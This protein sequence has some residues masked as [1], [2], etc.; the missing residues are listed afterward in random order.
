MFDAKSLLNSILGGAQQA[1]QAGGLSDIINQVQQGG[2]GNMIGSVLSQATQGVRDA[3]S[4]A[5]AASG[6]LGDRAN[7]ML[8][9][10]TG[11]QGVGDLVNKA[12]TMLGE[13]P[14]VA[15]AV[16]GGLGALVLGT[17]GGR[18]MAMSAAKLGGLALIGGLAYKA[19]QNYQS[20]KPLLNASAPAQIT[21]APQGSG[22]DEASHT[23]DST[24]ALLRAMIASA[25]ADGHIDETERAAIIGGLKQAG[26]DPEANDWLSNEMQTPATVD[27]LVALAGG[28]SELGAQIYTAARI[29]IDP[30]SA[31]EQD[32][33]VNLASGLG[34]D[35]EL[36]A[37]IDATAAQASA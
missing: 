28:S 22:F 11:S 10:A 5:N 25:A 27:D 35:A 20:G 36:V 1:G 14:A 6:G 16:L 32:F 7:D 18:G 33:L 24:I 4:Q 29:V 8:G 23:N 13:N 12:R 26:F 30:D 31:E 9:Q 2:I 37:H 19:Y 15:A 17:K 21:A 3:A 34:L